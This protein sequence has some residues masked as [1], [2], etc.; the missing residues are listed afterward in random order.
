MINF[1]LIVA[2]MKCISYFKCTAHK[3]NQ[4]WSWLCINEETL[5]HY[6]HFWSPVA[7]LHKWP[8]MQSLVIH[9]L[10][11]LICCWMNV[12]V[13]NDLKCHNA[14]VTS[15]HWNCDTKAALSDLKILSFTSM[16]I[17]WQDIWLGDTHAIRHYTG[18]IVTSL[19]VGKIYCVEKNVTK[20]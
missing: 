14:H 4:I 12:W 8:V 20:V 13:V 18:N 2:I 1:L 10:L 11:A 6:W 19:H 7:F 16:L 3:C 15:L 9:S 17:T 5:L